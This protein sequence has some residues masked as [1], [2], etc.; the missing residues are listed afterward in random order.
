MG[1][2]PHDFESCASASSA[3]AAPYEN[4]EYVT[5]RGKSANLP[6]TRLRLGAGFHHGGTNYAG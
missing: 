2:L 1:L 6:R 4:K 3:T 5:V